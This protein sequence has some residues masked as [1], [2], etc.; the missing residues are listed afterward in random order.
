MAYTSVP[1]LKQLYPMVNS[2]TT[3]TSADMFLFIQQADS[4]V[5][6]KIGKQ[7]TVPVSPTPPLLETLST[8]LAMYRLLALRFF[9]QKQMNDSVWPDR[10]K[11]TMA[12]LDQIAD[13]ELALVNS[14]GTIVDA[15]EGDAAFQTNNLNYNHTFTEDIQERSWVDADKIDAIRNARDQT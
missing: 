13:G 8:D 1:T 12:L 11:E 9:T 10:F 3:V 15:P 5:N 4:I 14:A 6:G 2:V 7:Y